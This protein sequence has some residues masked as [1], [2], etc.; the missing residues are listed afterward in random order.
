MP[1]VILLLAIAVAI[2]ILYR[3]AQ[4]APPEKRRAEFIKLGLAVMVV[5]VIVLTITGRMHWIG[6]AITGLLVGV[7]QF[8]PTLLRLFPMLASLRSNANSQKGTTPPSEGG[9]MT[10]EE[11]L[12]VLG[13]DGEASE[14]DIINAHRKMM[15]KIHP[16]RGGSDYLAAKINQAKDT[17]T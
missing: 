3:R 5:L 11:A 7:R 16:D 14:Q 2:Y 13:L 6:A 9:T 12:A 4:A 15:Q 17:L 1:R 10:A 8:L